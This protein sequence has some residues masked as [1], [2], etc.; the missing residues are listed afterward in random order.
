MCNF[1]QST[2]GSHRDGLSEPGEVQSGE[3]TGWGTG[4]GRGQV[5]LVGCGLS[6][7]RWAGA[8]GE[9]GAATRG[10]ILEADGPH[11]WGISLSLRPLETCSKECNLV[12]SAFQRE[13]LAAGWKLW[14]LSL[15]P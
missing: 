9:A 6:V 11:A 12:R 3:H 1:S 10:D 13:L 14:W 5:T 2:L 7:R 8:T 15:S 4:E